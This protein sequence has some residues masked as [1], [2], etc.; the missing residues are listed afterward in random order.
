MNIQRWITHCDTIWDIFKNPILMRIVAEWYQIK[1]DGNKLR[2]RQKS[3]GETIFTP[4][5]YEFIREIFEDRTD[6]ES[7]LG[8]LREVLLTS[9]AIYAKVKEDYSNSDII[10]ALLSFDELNDQLSTVDHLSVSWVFQ[11][12]IVDILRESYAASAHDEDPEEDVYPTIS[13]FSALEKALDHGVLP[14]SSNGEVIS[15]IDEG[16]TWYIV[17][18]IGE[19]RIF[20]VDKFGTPL[21]EE[22]IV[23]SGSELLD[24][25]E[26]VVERIKLLERIISYH[27]NVSTDIPEEDEQFYIDRKIEFS[28]EKESASEN[29]LE[30]HFG[31]YL[32]EMKNDL[33]EALKKMWSPPKKLEIVKNNNWDDTETIGQRSDISEIAI[34]RKQKPKLRIIQ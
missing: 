12:R 27:Y 11:T 19:S 16:N 25:R 6:M 28:G 31:K 33:V 1:K 20:E 34:V 29:L 32:T 13:I 8:Y 18:V 30:I 15:V 21:D 5:Y 14:I 3:N 26:K 22:V 7:F 2:W 10:K 17:S 23:E 24:T 4:E 9:D